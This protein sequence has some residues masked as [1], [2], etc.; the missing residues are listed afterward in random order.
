MSNR[1]N[2]RK[3]ANLKL[4]DRLWQSVGSERLELLNEKTNLS[5]IVQQK[6]QQVEQQRLNPQGSGQQ[7]QQ[8]SDA[9]DRQSE[10]ILDDMDNK[11]E[12]S[13][14]T[15]MKKLTCSIEES[16]FYIHKV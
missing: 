16:P 6:N 7:Q 5:Y 2:R 11:Y 4:I 9:F 12:K 10:A 14:A 13:R 1:T 3:F 8:T 15:Q